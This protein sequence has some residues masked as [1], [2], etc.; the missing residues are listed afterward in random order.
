MLWVIPSVFLIAVITFVLS[1]LVPGDPVLLY[2]N[3]GEQSQRVIPIQDREAFD[4][5]YASIAKKY[6]IDLPVFYFSVTPWSHSQ[7]DY[8]P[9]HYL[10]NGQV[11]RLTT[12]YG[13]AD[14]ARAYVTKKNNLVSTSRAGNKP[15]VVVRQLGKLDTAIHVKDIQS[16]LTD[17]EMIATFSSNESFLELKAIADQLDYDQARWYHFLPKVIWHG[18]QNQFHNWI[19]NLLV[20]K[21]GTSLTD[22]QPASLKIVRALSWSI[23]FNLMAWILIIGL[24]I[25]IGTRTALRSAGIGVKS[26]ETILLFIYGMP[27][28]WLASLAVIYL[29]GRA[30]WQIFPSPGSSRHLLSSG[31][32]RWLAIAGFL[33]LPLIVSIISAT[34]SLSRQMKH[35]IGMEIGKHYVQAAWLRGIPNRKLLW[36]YVLPNALAPMTVYISGIIP[37]LVSG[38]VVLENIFNIPGIGKLVVSSIYARD[39]NVAF[40]AFM[41]AAVLTVLSIVLADFL[42]SKLSPVSTKSLNRIN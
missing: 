18:T 35:L 25:F 38:S 5:Q 1:R 27:L 11:R 37:A 42:L 29:T 13:S 19:G 30:D 22:G 28:F 14:L 7:M 10:S 36:R 41:I 33:S 8:Q 24:S 6:G 39:W 26:V 40:L 34:A 20:G 17:S 21:W 31:L 15:P 16:I 3:R 2:M 9:Q 23:P 12:I 32:E 4:N